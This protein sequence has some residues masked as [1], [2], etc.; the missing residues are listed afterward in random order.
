MIMPIPS[1]KRIPESH[2]SHSGRKLRFFICLIIYAVLVGWFLYWPYTGDGDSALHYLNI[3]E[4]SVNP[5]AMLHPWARPLFVLVMLLPAMAG[6]VALHAFAAGLSVLLVWQTMRL[7]DDLEIPNSTL[8]GPLVMMQPLAFALASDF[9]TEIPMALGIV[10]AIRLWSAHRRTASCILVSLL[11]LV[12]PEGFILASAWGIIVLVT[13]TPGSAWRARLLQ[14]LCLGVGLASWTLASWVLAGN[15]LYWLDSGAWPAS[16]YESYGQGSLFYHVEQ[17]PKYCGEFLFVL[18]VVGLPW[19]VRFSMRLPWIVWALVLG[20]HSFLWWQGL[21]ASL[22]LM[23][24]LVTTSP[25]TALVCLH[26]WNAFGRFASRAG[27]SRRKRKLSATVILVIAGF[28]P[29]QQYYAVPEHHRCHVIRQVANFIREH[30]LLESRPRFFAGDEILIAELDFPPSSNL[31]VPNIWGRTEQ[32]RLLAGLPQGT[33]GVWDNQ[34]GEMWREVRIKDFPK[35][36][37]EII[38]RVDQTIRIFYF[39]LLM[40][41]SRIERQH[42]VVLRKVSFPGVVSPDLKEE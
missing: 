41:S 26:G 3:R 29:L 7:A 12:R 15:P 38:H 2:S 9:M 36:G 21:F 4:A 39:G 1:D 17:W 31:P 34:R 13:P 8:A 22:G 32:L 37:Y 40:P 5:V 14:C 19:S 11:P 24:I 30:H 35:I 23:R 10:L 33:V 25:I 20:V 42:Y 28:I 18:F 27:M 6:V 16:S